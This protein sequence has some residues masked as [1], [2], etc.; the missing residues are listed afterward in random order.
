MWKLIQEDDIDVVVSQYA[1]GVFTGVAPRLY[2]Q[3]LDPI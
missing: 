1:H 2:M 3:G